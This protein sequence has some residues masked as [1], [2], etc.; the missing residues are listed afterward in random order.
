MSIKKKLNE[1][2]YNIMFFFLTGE[3]DVLK[4]VMRYKL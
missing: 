3:N 1:I 2:Q 4:P